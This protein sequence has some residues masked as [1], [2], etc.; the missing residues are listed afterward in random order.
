MADMPQTTPLESQIRLLLVP[1]TGV[2]S[3][4]DDNLFESGLL[5]SLK[6]VNLVL[7][8]EETFKL[9]LAEAELDF[10]HMQSVRRIALWIGEQRALS[11]AQ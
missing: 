11:Q 3:G 7:T 6:V 10:D 1:I 5:D 2:E 9:P 4:L 8:L